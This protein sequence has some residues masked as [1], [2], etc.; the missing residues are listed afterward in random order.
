MKFFITG[1]AGFIGYHLASRLLAEGHGVVG[2]DGVT[3]NQDV[4]LK[5]MR[6]RLLSRHDRFL[7]V[8]SMLEDFERLRAAAGAADPDVMIHLAGQAGVRL[9]VEHPR[10]YLDSNVIGTF[11]LLEIARELRP[12]HLMLASTSSV[13]GANPMTPQAESQGT[14][15]PTSPY[16]ATKKATEVLSHSHAHLWR[17]PTTCLRFFSVY[18]PWGRRDMALSQFVEAI[19]LG[20]PLDVFGHGEMKRDFTYIDDLVESVVRLSDCIPGDTP[21][22]S[23]I[24]PDT[25]S[26]AAPWRVVNI[27]GGFPVGLLEFISVIEQCLGRKALVNL[28]PMREGEMETTFADHR[29]LQS[30]TGYRPATPLEVG[31]KAFVKWRRSLRDETPH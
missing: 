30:L 24:A 21:A 19:E 3:P 16:A 26:S 29:L 6:H 15:W 2:Y 23:S 31:V 28:R 18:G 17:I 7:G 12:R 5:R 14:D 9:S 13:Y 1:T 27:G 20:K 22:A 4:A 25:L 10:A 8:E 11:N